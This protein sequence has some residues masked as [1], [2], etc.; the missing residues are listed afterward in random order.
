MSRSPSKSEIQSNSS[1]NCLAEIGPFAL[2]EF[3]DKGGMGEVWRAFHRE[4]RL[5]VAVK[6]IHAERARRNKY[7]RMFH[8]E[9]QSVAK[10]DHPGIVTLYDYGRISD[11]TAAETGGEFRADSPYLAME[12]CPELGL[13]EAEPV[14]S[15]RPCRGILL[16]ILDSLAHAHARG[17][18]HRDIKPSNVL[19]RRQNSSWSGVKLADFGLAFLLRGE[20]SLAEQSAARGTPAYMA[21]E[22]LRAHWRDLGPWSDLYSVGCL[23]YEVVTGRRPFEGRSI[24]EIAKGHLSDPVP[25]LEPRFSVPPL[26]ESWLLRLLHKSPLKRYRSAA[27]AAWG[28]LQL[29]G[30]LT[31]SDRERPDVTSNLESQAS[32]EPETLFEVPASAPDAST[33][34]D[35]NTQQDPRKAMPR[36][37]APMPTEWQTRSERPGNRLLEPT[38]GL[39]GMRRIP[40]V[41]R[42]EIRDHLWRTLCEVRDGN[43]YQH[44]NLRG[45]TGFGKRTL[46][47]WLAERAEET[48]CATTLS[49]AGGWSDTSSV[50]DALRHFFRTQE[51]GRE[52]TWKRLDDYFA[53]LDQPHPGLTQ[54]AAIVLADGDEQVAMA[55]EAQMTTL[56]RLM[57]QM[58]AYRPLVVIA[59]DLQSSRAVVEFLD[60]ARGIREFLEASI[61]VVST[62]VSED[63]DFSASIYEQWLE[64]DFFDEVSVGRLPD[65]DMRRLLARMLR[66]AGRLSDRIISQA[67]GN[68][69]FAIQLVESWAQNDLMDWTPEGFV[70]S[71]SAEATIPDKALDV[72]QRRM[73]SATAELTNDQQVALEMAA[74][75]GSSVDESLWRAACDRLDLQ[76]IDQGPEKLLEARLAEPTSD[77]WRFVH[78]MLRHSFVSHAARQEHLSALHRSAAETLAERAPEDSERI[79][80]HW[81]NAGDARRAA[82]P[83]VTALA[84]L[85]ERQQIQRG[86][87]LLEMAGEVISQLSLASDSKLELEFLR[88]KFSY[89]LNANRFTGLAEEIENAIERAKSA[90]HRQ[91]EH[92]LRMRQIEY[93]QL[94]GQFD[95]VIPMAD[96]LLAEPE[97]SPSV[98]Y[99][100]TISKAKILSRTGGV[101]EAL[102]AAAAFKDSSKYDELSERDSLVVDWIIAF[103]LVRLERLEE[104]YTKLGDVAEAYESRGNVTH[105][106]SARLAQANAAWNLER[107]DD[108]EQICRDTLDMVRGVNIR[109][110]QNA[111]L[112]LAFALYH[113]GDLIEASALMQRQLTDIRREGRTFVESFILLGLAGVEAKRKNWDDFEMRLAQMRQAIDDSGAV[114]TDIP[115]LMR[116]AADLATQSGRFELAMRALEIAESQL[117]TLELEE[118]LEDVR[119]ELDR[120]RSRDTEG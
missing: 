59:N 94:K 78:T 110:V 75:L 62:T 103:S 120:L 52:E 70:L 48:G 66:L 49:L 30:D 74:V 111:E 17:V 58:A 118:S 84:E 88:S 95:R 68:P 44:I 35:S 33:D 114:D 20:R 4:T 54:S 1:S 12:F 119:G 65:A 31:E 76:D 6:V 83:L 7:Q 113:K 104:A 15:W 9:A 85:W 107:F 46:S 97:L 77:G 26:F 51:L 45:A 34:T 11:A 47:R 90:G 79:G 22:Q 99:D 25:P 86:Q 100:A 36:A 38:L 102:E 43:G 105:A 40:V 8:S 91:L 92:E 5:E 73:S 80:K 63:A 116:E 61:L 50:A 14:S 42:G 53:Q 101:R 21:P 2:V 29:R 10:L 112:H 41:D 69:L 32:Y 60:H 55:H 93:H 89:E 87:R 27:D 96:E 98:E 115:R 117:D 16:S 108:A 56:A 37:Q 57:A 106:S 81:Y 24:M 82:A 64:K 19:L 71:D 67:D 109:D 72:W 18:L 39:L 13:D 23:A 3:I 28:L